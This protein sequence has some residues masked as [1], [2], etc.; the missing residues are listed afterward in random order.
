MDY[1][2]L[3]DFSHTV[4]AD[5]IKSFEHH[6][7][8]LSGIGDFVRE[9]GSKL[10]PSEYT[11]I[12]DGVWVHKTA[13]VF[14]TAFITGPVIIGPR[15][16]VFHCAI[17]R[18]GVLIGSDC[19]VGSA[20][21]V[22]SSILFDNVEVCHFNYIGDSILG[23]HVHFGAGAITSNV[24]SDR[25]NIQIHGD[26]KTDTGSWKLGACIGD[27]VEVGCNSVLNPGV[28][29]GRNTTIYPCLSVRGVIPENRILKTSEILVS[30]Y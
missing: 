5:Y 19:V 6:W 27:H 16:S 28:I 1:T 23:H 7:E 25:T 18:N 24:K 13:S 4:A 12:S 26:Q 17:I 14:P 10:D 11:Q 22:K 3:F 21:E 8:A 20:V 29:I 9:L 30:K 2:R 15:S